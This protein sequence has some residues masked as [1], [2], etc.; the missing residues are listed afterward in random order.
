M[1]IGDDDGGGIQSSVVAWA[2]V[3]I[4]LVG[5]RFRPALANFYSRLKIKDC[6][7]ADTVCFS[8][9]ELPLI[10]RSHMRFAF[11]RLII[12]FNQHVETFT[13][14]NKTLVDR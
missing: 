10:S 13:P 2:E 12:I 9:I 8:R 4:S 14:N 5:S 1:F 6:H 11:I 3:G 7:D